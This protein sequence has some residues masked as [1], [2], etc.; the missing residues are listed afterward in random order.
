MA[1]IAPRA[2]LVALLRN[3][4]DKVYSAYHF[5]GSRRGRDTS[6]FEKYA[7]AALEDPR[8]RILSQGIYV[9]QLLRWSEFF[10]R[11]QMLVLKSEDFFDDPRRTL[12]AVLDFFD[13]PAWE[14]DDSELSQKRNKGPY[15]QGMEPGTRRRLEE[16]YEPHNQRLY[17]YLGVD[18][19]W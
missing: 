18:F 1:E 6:E 8:L 16:F 2:R 13:L 7:D 12:N 11:D 14:P 5:F 9:D 15:E 17:D 4:V 3:P 19:G 10:P